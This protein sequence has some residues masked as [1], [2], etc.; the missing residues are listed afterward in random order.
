ME[1]ELGEQLLNQSVPSSV[2]ST[3]RHPDAQQ[4]VQAFASAAQLRRTASEAVQSAP[5]RESCLK[6]WWWWWLDEWM[7]WS[8][9]VLNPLVLCAILQAARSYHADRPGGPAPNGIQFFVLPISISWAFLHAIKINPVDELD[10]SSARYRQCVTTGWIARL[11]C[12]SRTKE[13]TAG[14][15]QTLKR[16]VPTLAYNVHFI[17][18]T[19]A[20]TTSWP[21]GGSYSYDLRRYFG[22]VGILLACI[23]LYWFFVKLRIAV[24]GACKNAD[25]LESFGRLARRTIFAAI[26]LE[27]LFLG[28]YV[29]WYYDTRDA[30]TRAQ[31]NGF[32]GTEAVGSQTDAVGNSAIIFSMCSPAVFLSFGSLWYSAAFGID[33]HVGVGIQVVIIALMFGAISIGATWGAGKMAYGDARF[34]QSDGTPCTPDC[35]AG[36]Q[37]NITN[38]VVCLAAFSFFTGGCHVNLLQWWAAA[39]LP[40]YMLTGRD[41]LS[42]RRFNRRLQLPDGKQYHYFICHHQGSGGNQA[43]ILYDQLTGLGC[44]VWYDN[45]MP[46]TERNLDGMQR[47]VRASVTLLLFLSGREETNGQ[48]DKNGKYEGEKRI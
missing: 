19:A 3:G 48:P 30:L 45:E 26:V 2:E 22:M 18:L 34:E 40:V 9:A 38:P 11:C 44:S 23:F 28:K 31:D 10:E 33:L 21:V 12:C 42:R 6:Q 36:S 32:P 46:A 27:F 7:E 4:P 39:W 37:F 47:G 29:N 15:T 8:L 16:A 20:V 25:E 13:S 17:L 41:L 43:K 1:D 24:V 5:A 35:L 14:E